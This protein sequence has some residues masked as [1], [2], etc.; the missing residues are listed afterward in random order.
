MSV[1]G[2]IPSP[3]PALLTRIT[4]IR[5]PEQDR[6]TLVALNHHYVRSVGEADTAWFETSLAKDFLNT[7]PDETLMGR[8]AFI[9]QTSR[10]SGLRNIREHAAV[11]R[12]FGDFA[13]THARTTVQQPDGLEGGGRYTNDWLVR[14]GSWRCVSARVT[15][16]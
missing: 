4:A 6:E 16:L 2:R 9:A 3:K 10:V 5:T 7:N 12:P 14:E 8:A 1:S 11:V 13:I 15:R